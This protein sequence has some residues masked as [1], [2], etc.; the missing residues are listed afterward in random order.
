MAGSLLYLKIFLENTTTG[1]SGRSLVRS[2]RIFIE[3]TG[4]VFV[5]TSTDSLL[6]LRTMFT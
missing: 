5:K 2:K 6:I 1:R 4:P 3:R